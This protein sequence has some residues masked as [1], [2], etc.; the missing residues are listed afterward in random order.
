MRRCFFAEN[1]VLV[2]GVAGV[3]GALDCLF[4]DVAVEMMKLVIFYS[5]CGEDHAKIV[6][7]ACVH[8]AGLFLEVF[9]RLLWE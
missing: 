3:L 4:L 9:Q 7:K 1:G 8:A 5:Q 2:L 6:P